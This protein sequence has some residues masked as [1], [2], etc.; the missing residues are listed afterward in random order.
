MAVSALRS[1]CLHCLDL[2]RSAIYSHDVGRDRAVS[3]TSGRLARPCRELRKPHR[4]TC[5]VHFYLNSGRSALT[6]PR[7]ICSA[8]DSTGLTLTHRESTKESVGG[9][10]E[11]ECATV[12]QTDRKCKV[13]VLRFFTTSTFAEEN[14][15][16]FVS[17]VHTNLVRHYFFI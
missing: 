4:N 17:N 8:N 10:I 2:Q 14:K 3:A 13:H 7:F 11:R 5:P 16:I 15:N 6:F 9:G 12:G 1:L